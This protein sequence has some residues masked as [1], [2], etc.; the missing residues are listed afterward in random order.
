M[1]KYLC[2]GAAGRVSDAAGRSGDSPGERRGG[3]EARGRGG[4]LV[5]SYE[6]S[7][8]VR[9]RL[10]LLLGADE[11]VELGIGLGERPVVEGKLLG[12]RC[13]GTKR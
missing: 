5:G 7:K 3:V 4:R 6:G 11:G 9:S 13:G 12:G 10:A 8:G 1:R 2:R